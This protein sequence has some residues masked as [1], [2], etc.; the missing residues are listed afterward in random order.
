MV[1]RK[2]VGKRIN[3]YREKYL[4]MTQADFA[5][6]LGMEEKR[7]RSTINNWEQGQVQIKS[8][9]LTN[10]SKTFGVSVDWLLGLSDC[11]VIDEDIKAAHKVTGLSEKALNSFRTFRALKDS[12]VAPLAPGFYDELNSILESWAELKKICEYIVKANEINTLLKDESTE[13]KQRKEEWENGISEQEKELA[14]EYGGLLLNP[15]DAV[16]F[17][18]RA[19]IDTFGEIVRKRIEEA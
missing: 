8:D 11:P 19:A 3:E 9:D 1:E 14:T 12:P 6:E 13:G 15:E 10:I 17:Y 7:G 4:H 16:Q 5:V 18:K 2:E